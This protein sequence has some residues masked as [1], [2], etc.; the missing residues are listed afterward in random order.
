MEGLVMGKEFLLCLHARA[1]GI[2]RRLVHKLS[3]LAFVDVL[4]SML[5]CCGCREHGGLT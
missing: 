1:M 4:M 5:L 2:N 3:P